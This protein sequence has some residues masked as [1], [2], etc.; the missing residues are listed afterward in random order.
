MQEKLSIAAI[1]AVVTTVFTTTLVMSLTGQEA[2][3]VCTKSG[4]CAVTNPPESITASSNTHDIA[5]NVIGG[6][7]AADNNKG[8]QGQ[9]LPTNTPV[10]CHTTLRFAP[11]STE[12]SPNNTRY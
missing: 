3:A 1:I 4:A 6:S 7:N 8:N 9:I 5:G 11:P 2:N 10:S 12:P